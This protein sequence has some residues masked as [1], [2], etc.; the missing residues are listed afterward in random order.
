MLGSALLSARLS[1]AAGRLG[2]TASTFCLF[3]ACCALTADMYRILTSVPGSVGKGIF[4]EKP[5]ARRE[6]LKA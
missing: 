3:P 4:V 6:E 5:P 2:A 1:V